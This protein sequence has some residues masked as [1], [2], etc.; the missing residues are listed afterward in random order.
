MLD[1]MERAPR[2]TRAEAT[3]AA[4]A[5][6]VKLWLSVCERAESKVLN[7]VLDGTDVVMLSG[8]T[9]NGKFPE[10]AVMTMRRIC[11]QAEAVI[12]YQACSRNGKQVL[13]EVFVNSGKRPCTCE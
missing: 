7:A 9:A 1:S 13:L 4:S 5:A 12:D 10:A 11:E 3:D 8:E 2:P 6:M